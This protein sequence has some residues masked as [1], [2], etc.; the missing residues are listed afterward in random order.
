MQCV[1]PASDYSLPP[2]YQND[3]KVAMTSVAV[4]RAEIKRVAKSQ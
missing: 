3:E 1:N 2:Y 4:I